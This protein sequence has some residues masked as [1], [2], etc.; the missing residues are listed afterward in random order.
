[1]SENLSCD[2]VVRE[3]WDWLDKELDEA[4]WQ[5]LET[6]LS[7]CTGCTAHVDFARRFLQ[8]VHDAPPTGDL[9]A[10]R[11]R[12]LTALNSGN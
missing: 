3:I 7:S 8:H 12:V 2:E 6:H 11:K 1:M 9:G 5:Q 10:L 4:R